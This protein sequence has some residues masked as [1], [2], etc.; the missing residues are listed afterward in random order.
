M[1]FFVSRPFVIALTALALLSPFLFS[2][3]V[4]VFLGVVAGLYMPAVPFFVGVLVDL[5]YYPG[6]TLP[7][8]LCGGALV[9]MITYGVRYLV[10]TRI[11]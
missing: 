4:T 6:H 5:L 3:A 1:S 8:G 2:S 10:R 9:C 11:M 7:L